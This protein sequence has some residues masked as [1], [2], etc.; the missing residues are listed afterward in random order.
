MKPTVLLSIVFI[1]QLASA[2]EQERPPHPPL[3]PI[4]FTLDLDGDGT[5]SAEEIAAASESLSTLDSDDNG[6]LSDE[7][8]APEPTSGETGETSNRSRRGQGP[9]PSPLMEALD[10]N[11]DGT[12]SK[13]ELGKAADH[14]A[15]LDTNEDGSLSEDELLPEPPEPGMTQGGNPPQGG[16]PQGGGGRPPHPPHS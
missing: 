10:H 3:P 2:Q 6:R 15:D 16:P 4:F 7:E 13:G 8:M 1:G 12:I 11:G 9:P 5:I 14:L